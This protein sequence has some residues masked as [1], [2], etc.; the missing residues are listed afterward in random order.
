MRKTNLLV[1]TF[2]GMGLMY[3]CGGNNSTDQQDT[4][5]KGVVEQMTESASALK[6]LS[7]LEEY[8]KEL[9]SR[10]N[11][12]KALKPVSN[13]VLKSVLPET[14]Q[15]L[16]RSSLNVGE[17][18]ALGFANA[19]AEYKNEDGSKIVNID[20]MDGAGEG[21]A[22]IVS[23]VFLGLNAEKEEI[24]DTGFEKT[25]DIEGTRALVKEESDQGV[26]DS[27]IQWV[28]DKRFVI[29][30]EGEGYSLD[31]LTALFKSLDLSSL[32]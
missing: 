3:S 25:M 5:D 31:E 1:T 22:S 9:E 27:E 19:K 2:L 21:A 12:L 8:G 32:K 4:D 7:K 11:E 10:M 29:K 30:L 16:K 13:D 20:I 23:L 28:H 24:T 18:S 14:I 15:E 17:M 26:K 6:N